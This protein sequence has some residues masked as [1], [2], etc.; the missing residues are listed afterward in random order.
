MMSSNRRTDSR[1]EISSCLYPSR[2]ASASRLFAS[3]NFLLACASSRT[4]PAISAAS[5]KFPSSI[6]SCM[7]RNSASARCAT[8]RALRTGS[9]SFSNRERNSAV[10]SWASSEPATSATTKTAAQKPR[11]AGKVLPLPVR[12]LASQR[13]NTCGCLEVHVAVFVL[14]QFQEFLICVE[15]WGHLVQ[16]IVTSGANEPASRRRCFSLRQHVQAVQRGG[17]IL[18]EIFR[19]HQILQH[20]GGL[21]I[22]SKRSCQFVNGICV[23][24]FLQVHVPQ[25][26]GKVG[27]LRRQRDRLQQHWHRIVILFFAEINQRAQLQHAQRFGRWACGFIKL[28][29]RVIVLARVHQQGSVLQPHGRVVGMRGEVNAQ[30]RRGFVVF[31][32]CEQSLQQSLMGLVGRDACGLQRQR[33]AKRCFGVACLS[34]LQQRESER[35]ANLHVFWIEFFRGSIL[36]D[37]R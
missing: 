34:R 6:F 24:F 8:S 35:I 15:R 4:R 28:G 13:S 3:S 11:R 18:A 22:H 17:V 2:W 19:R 14:V 9:V 36:F 12:E 16:F 23:I 27:I 10:R 5:D 37:G 7:S 1:T 20:V 31:F 33:L 29:Q 26:R 30:L 25:L 21:P 32:L